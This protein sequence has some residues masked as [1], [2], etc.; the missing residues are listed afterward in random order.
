M[1]RI[2]KLIV[3]G[4]LF[5][6]AWSCKKE[7]VDVL[8]NP[9]AK[10][11]ATASSATAVLLKDNATKDAF[12]VSWITPEYGFDAA[13]Q[14][15]LLIVKKGGDFTK[16]TTIGLGAKLSKVFTTAELNNA[17]I[18]LGIAEGTAG[19]VD[20]RVEALVGVNTKLISNVLSAKITTYVDKFNP[21]SP[22][23]VVGDAT[24]NGWNGPDM[25][26]QRIQDANNVV[27]K[28]NIV[29]FVTL[30]DGQIKFRRNNDWTVNLGS[31]GTIE[32]DPAQTG[33][34]SAGGKNIGVKKGTYKITVDTLLNKY[35]I[36]ALS[37]GI[38]GD[39]T[40]NGWAGPDQAMSFDVASG[41]WKGIINVVD[42]SIK[43]RL[44]NDWGTNYGAATGADGDP[45]LAAGPL[46][47][48]GKNLGVKKGT[49]LVTLDLNTLKYTF[50]AFKTWGLVGDATPGGWNGPDQAFTYDFA[51]KKW[52]LKNVVLTTASVKFRE[53]NDWA[54]NLGA[55]GTVEPFPIVTT[56]V[57]GPLIANGKNFGVT[58][59]TW[60]FE[61]DLNDAANPKY[62]AKK[63]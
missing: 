38:V 25:P 29:A 6:S 8:I 20:M 15:S 5:M 60:S 37:W 40:A 43:F 10:L 36:E 50:V 44:N 11:V 14:Y 22:W 9:N 55:T 56:T 28:D 48:G 4:L 33:T 13:P 51:T 23:G 39:A 47:A 18:A 45:I 17:A 61:L 54:N 16:A 24:P 7:I 3:F 19:D 32:P 63:Q 53:G 26:M 2:N 49:Y 52:T 30:A 12:T 42:G 34:L 57:G 46:A 21:Y 62:V 58:A 31:S 27:I 1:K 35:K 59:G 41:L